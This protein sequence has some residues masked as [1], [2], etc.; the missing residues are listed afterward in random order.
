MLVVVA[1]VETLQEQ[2]L[3]DLEVEEM[4]EQEQQEAMQPQ[5]LEAVEVV[6]VTLE[7]IQEQL[8]VVGKV[9]QV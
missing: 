4:V 3:V 5:T 1:V 6:L 9:V 2:V 8:E 7:V